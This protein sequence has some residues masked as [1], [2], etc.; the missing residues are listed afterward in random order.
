MRL[1]C[2]MYDS[3]KLLTAIFVSSFHLI[4]YKH[5]QRL[6]KFC[7]HVEIP[8]MY[9]T[10]YCIERTKDDLNRYGCML[11]SS[12][13]SLFTVVVHYRANACFFNQQHIYVY[14]YPVLVKRA[15]LHLFGLLS[16]QISIS[17]YD[18]SIIFAHTRFF[19]VH[20]RHANV[21]Y[22]TGHNVLRN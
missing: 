3:V 15:P 6:T 11:Y 4:P 17:L 14:I 19:C 9:A 5:S 16:M 20:R 12:I 2:L 1:H 21:Y 10:L 8:Y 22:W 13:Y 7:H 18:I